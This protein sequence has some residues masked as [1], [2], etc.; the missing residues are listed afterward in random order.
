MIRFGL[1]GAGWRAE[2]FLRIAQ[3]LP[4][5]FQITGVVTRNAD[6]AARMRALFNV[7]VVDSD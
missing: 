1:I 2:F 5:R 7:N 3:A 4:D 6:R